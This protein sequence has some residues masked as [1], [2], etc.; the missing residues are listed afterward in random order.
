M[1]W[2]YIYLKVNHSSVSSSLSPAKVCRF[3]FYNYRLKV[4]REGIHSV[5]YF[6]TLSPGSTYISPINTGVSITPAAKMR[7]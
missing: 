5:V 2:M 3:P 1:C 4:I 6:S 7:I